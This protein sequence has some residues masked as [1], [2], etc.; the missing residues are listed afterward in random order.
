[1]ATLVEAR[2]L[3]KTYREGEDARVVLRD[4]EVSIA[5][6]ELAVVVGRSGSG[7][8]TLLNLIGGI[9]TPTAGEVVIAGTPLT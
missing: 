6:G 7:K 3:T 5:R 1:M 9:D 8:S 2:G 4:V